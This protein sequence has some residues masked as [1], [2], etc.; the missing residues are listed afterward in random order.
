M[1]TEPLYETHED[2]ITVSFP[3]SS[4]SADFH[5]FWLRHNCDCKNGCRH[6]KTN[7]RVVDSSEIP[8]DI[9][10]LSVTAEENTLV[11]NWPPIADLKEQASH[12]SSYEWSW[13]NKYAY[14]RNH[15]SV[16][17]IPHDLNT[18]EI[19]YKDWLNKYP[20]DTKSDGLSQEGWIEYRKA[21]GRI[22]KN[23]G[24]L[25]VR[26]RGLDTEGIISDLLPDGGHVIETHFGRIEDLRTDNTTNKNTD[27]L[28]YT[29]AGVNLH[30]DQPFIENPPGMQALQCVTPADEGGDNFIV[31]ARRAAE[32]LRDNNPI[33]FE[34]LT[35][36][37]VNFHRKQEKFESVQK[38]TLIEVKENGEIG[39]MR[40]SYFTYAP[41]NVPFHL[42]K[43]WYNA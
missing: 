1:T 24:L 37:P 42:M 26:N 5:Y 38:R 6:V 9:K 36:Y 39:M 22:I 7:E 40:Y 18:V 8:M 41:H 28:G 27:Q 17:E 2:Y 34:M 19:D 23:Y 16:T 20:H 4:S 12:V 14:A 25:V 29:N 10:P 15:V 35:R 21:C 31:D 33:A 32:W 11:I 3:N 13:L 30:T 43:E